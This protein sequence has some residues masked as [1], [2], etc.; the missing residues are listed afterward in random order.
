LVS[1]QRIALKAVSASHAEDDPDS[2]FLAISLLG[3]LSGA[4]WDARHVGVAAPDVKMCGAS[5][6]GV[7]VLTNQYRKRWERTW[8]V[9]HRKNAQ[10][11]LGLPLTDALVDSL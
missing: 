6:G 11:L 9:N 8:L 10:K 3:L 4:K 7:P 1:A 5:L 2:Y